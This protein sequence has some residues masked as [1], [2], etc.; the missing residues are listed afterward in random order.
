MNEE[1]VI[2]NT[3]QLK[4]YSKKY[5][6]DKE[7]SIKCYSRKQISALYPDKDYKI[8][9]E[10]NKNSQKEAIGK[11]TVDDKEFELYEYKSHSRLIYHNSGFLKCEGKSDSYIVLLKN[12]LLIRLLALLLVFSSGSAAYYLYTNWDILFPAT[13][14]SINPDLDPNAVD[15]TGEETESKSPTKADS[16]VI[17]GKRTII[18]PQGTK[19]VKVA[20]NNPSENPCY[21][22]VSIV[23]ENSGYVLYKS[24]MIAPGKAVYN[25]TLKKEMEAGTYPINIGY[26]T[27][28]I[29]NL[30]PLNG[31]NLKAELIVK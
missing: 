23:L 16:I 1:K 20:F 26:D 30:S 4:G 6:L 3:Q 18:I 8:T 21:F 7:T 9:G 28:D 14:S 24:K 15:W 31:A 2:V 19:D 12:V 13:Q 5:K 27:Y 10:F 22:V 25:I 17:P 11:F 29:N